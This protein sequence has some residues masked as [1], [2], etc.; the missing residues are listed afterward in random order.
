MA[1]GHLAHRRHNRK[2]KM[3]ARDR[4]ACGPYHDLDHETDNLYHRH[5]TMKK[6]Y[7]SQQMRSQ[8]QSQSQMVPTTKDLVRC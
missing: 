1:G 6:K 4:K 5:Q 3:N 2:D 8:V 7:Q